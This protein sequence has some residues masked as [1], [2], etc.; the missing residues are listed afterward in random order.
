[1]KY[2]DKSNKL[3][4]SE[5]ERL[6][7]QVSELEISRAELERAERDLRIKDLAIESSINAIGITDL[8]GTVIYVNAACVKMWGFENKE[9][10]IGRSLFEF[11]E[12]DGVLQTVKTLHEEGGRIGE[13]IGKRKDGSLFNVQFST[14]MIR[15]ESG[16]PQFMLGSFIDITAQK[17]TA[18]V[19]RE[20]EEKFRNLAEQSPNM[21]F[22]HAIDRIVYANRRCEEVMEYTRKEF[23]SPTFDFFCLI[24]PESIALAKSNFSLHLEGLEVEPIEYKLLTRSG[25]RIEV[26]LTTRLIDFMG[27]KTILGIIT[28]ITVQKKAEEGLKQ[29]KE[30]L[31]NLASH[32]QT[33]REEERKRIAREIHD[34]LGQILIAI[35]ME[36]YRFDHEIPAGQKK[37]HVNLQSILELIDST[38]RSVS[39]IQAELRPS[40]LDELGLVPALEWY[41]GDF[42]KRTG[43]FCNI[44]KNLE[45]TPVDQEYTLAVFRIFQ[46]A[47]TNIARHAEATRVEINLVIKD[48]VLDMTIEDNGKGISTEQLTSPHSFGLIGIRE[49]VKFMGGKDKI[50]GFRG[51]GTMV[52]VRVPLQKR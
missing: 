45:S 51:K 18:N 7:K 33:V 10:I 39:R 20:S 17:K 21:I 42:Q 4:V 15:D 31:Q 24:T 12:G 9:E 30:K 28:D 29:S 50:G 46:E 6:Q 22:I 37:L 2:M 49:R 3:L 48:G 19:L 8:N 13:D 16:N 27:K 14:S 38:I 1:M 40:V 34:E 52:S 44:S 36:L 11:W 32:L 35:K 47:L 26:I 5:L 25:K 43:I 41:T 23:Y